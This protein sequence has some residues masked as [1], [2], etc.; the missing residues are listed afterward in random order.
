MS[1]TI[2]ER[3]RDAAVTRDELRSERHTAAEKILR[4]G[5]R[6]H[7]ANLVEIEINYDT[8]EL[9]RF[10]VEIATDCG[11]LFGAAVKGKRVNERFFSLDAALIAAVA[12]DHLG[13]NEAR[14]A[15]GFA[16]RAL[17]ATTE[18]A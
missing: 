9:V 12:Y 15:I 18:T 1:E 17:G 3:L 4:L 8:N 13:D 14:Y 6:E 5:H 2:T 10:V 11:S 7:I 16:E